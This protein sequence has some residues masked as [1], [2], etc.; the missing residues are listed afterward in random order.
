M[1]IIW[2]DCDREGENIGFEVITVC[3]NGKLLIPN[4]DNKQFHFIAASFLKL[5]ILSK[6]CNF[7]LY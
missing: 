7:H 6:Y 1:L 2:T 3:Q 4:L 5:Y